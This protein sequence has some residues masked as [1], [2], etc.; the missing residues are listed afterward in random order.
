MVARETSTTSLRP[1]GPL[2]PQSKSSTKFETVPAKLAPPSL[3]VSGPLPY[4][5][6]QDGVHQTCSSLG[7]TLQ[8][9]TGYQ[10][11]VPQH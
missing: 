9:Q 8:S 10:R 1:A 5:I 7:P 2:V 11:L 4:T 3:G 6:L